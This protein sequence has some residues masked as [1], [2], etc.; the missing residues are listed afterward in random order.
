MRERLFAVIARLL[1]LLT[2][3]GYDRSTVVNNLHHK[4]SYRLHRLK[5][6]FGLSGEKTVQLTFPHRI[7]LRMNA[8][9]GGVAHQFIVYREYEP[10]ETDLVKAAVRLGNTVLN[11]GANIGY[12]AVLCSGLVGKAGKVIA[13]EPHPDNFQLLRKNIAQNEAWNV[14]ALEVAA[15]AVEGYIQ[16]FPS[17]TNSG[18]HSVF[19]RKDEERNPIDIKV[20]TLDNLLQ[21]LDIEPDVLIIDV[22]GAELAVLKGVQRYLHKRSKPLKLFLEVWPQGIRMTEEDPAHLFSLLEEVNSNLSLI[23][24]K[25]KKLN[26]LS[27]ADLSSLTRSST[28][29]NLFCEIP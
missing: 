22:Q 28:E 19:L 4:L 2:G 6:L 8:D 10:F 11:V 5:P 12:Y 29:F 14:E 16:L 13:L 25:A 18:D 26:P 15:G 3:K 9:D 21:E 1:V 20:V 24:E 23:D 27:S 7:E 17:R